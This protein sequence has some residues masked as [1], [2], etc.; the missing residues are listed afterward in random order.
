M[1]W[2]EN[3][4]AMKADRTVVYA[5]SSTPWTWEE[6]G[7][8]Q[9]KQIKKDPPKVAL[10]SPDHECWGYAIKDYAPEVCSYIDENYV[11]LPNTATVYV[12]KSYYKDACKKMNIK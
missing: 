11:L 1:T 4:D 2:F 12:L 10:Y 5:A 3:I 6:W 9:M 8:Q 7:K